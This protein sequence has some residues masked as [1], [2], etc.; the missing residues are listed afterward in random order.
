MN[1]IVSNIHILIHGL[2]YLYKIEKLYTILHI[3]ASVMAPL[4]PYINIFMMAKILN[5]LA[6]KKD[7]FT[8]L[9]Y[10]AITIVGNLLFSIILSALNQFKSFHLNQFYKSE[11][12]LFAE[13]SMLMDFEQIEDPSIHALLERIQIGRAHV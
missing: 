11:K 6:G 13:K 8:L 3:A 2:T 9:L 1:K 7:T 12:M 10:V 5:E 4:Q